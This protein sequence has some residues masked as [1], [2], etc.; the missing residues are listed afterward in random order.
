MFVLTKDDEKFVLLPNKPVYTVG[1]LQT[2]L[3]LLEDLSI[4]RTHARLHLPRE[5]DGVLQI[6]DKGS[7]YGTFLN[8][9]IARNKKMPPNTLTPLPVGFKVRFGGSRNIWQVTQMPLVS[10]VSA[11][12]NDQVK[13]LGMLLAAMGGSVCLNWGDAD[14]CT[15][16]T[17]NEATVTVKLLHALLENKPIVTFEYWRKLLAAAQGIHVREGWPQPEDYQPTNMDLSWRPERTTLFANKTFVFMNRRHF[18]IYGAVVRKAGALCKDLNSGVRKTFLTKKDV[19]VIQY[20]PSTQSQSTETINSIQN[21]LE[22]AG[23]RIIQEYEIGMALLRCSTKEFCNPSHKLISESMP[24]TE[25]MTSSFNC[26]I[27]APNTEERSETNPAAVPLSEL[28]VPESN[29]HKLES[30]SAKPETEPQ[31]PQSISRRQKRG[32]LI[33]VDSSDE[34]QEARKKKKS[35]EVPAVPPKP[36]NKNAILDSSDE[37]QTEK[38]KEDASVEENNNSAKP[39]ANTRQSTRGKANTENVTKPEPAR[40]RPSTRSAPKATP[41]VAA[42]SDSEDDSA[43][44]QFTEKPQEAQPPKPA[45]TSDKPPAKIR[46]INFLEKSQPQASVAAPSQSQPQPRKRLRLEP[47]NESDSD[48]CDN[49]FNFD[50][51]R[52]KQKKADAEHTDEDLFNFQTHNRNASED[53]P[54]NEDDVLTE[55]FLSNETKQPLSKY[56]VF[57]RKALP[58]KIDTSGWLSCSRLHNETKAEANLSGHMESTSTAGDDIALEHSI[59]EE[60]HTKWLAVRPL[61]TPPSLGGRKRFVKQKVLHY[62]RQSVSL[63]RLQLADGIVSSS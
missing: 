34:E 19:I 49:L 2:D 21:I 32:R 30:E 63:H 12:S 56:V 38:P 5:R 28:F 23:L 53:Q 45:E 7:K 6:E 59:K 51:D 27:L 18:E 48:D 46:V 1:R 36:W 52:K 60:T 50:S 9:D 8:N 40:R 20:V 47:L 26:S 31:A 13:E 44:F 57:P 41:A 58:R 15:H 39:R 10:A 54:Q 4:S 17:M 3:I 33:I 35:L 14:E 11:L 62:H 43:L 61:E 55:P 29:V 16:L 37:E 22:Q 42:A 25:S 24:T